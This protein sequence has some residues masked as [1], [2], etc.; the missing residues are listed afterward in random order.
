[1]YRLWKTAYNRYKLMYNIRTQPNYQF[2]DFHRIQKKKDST[3][4]LNCLIEVQS[5]QHF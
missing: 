3:S 4:V 1:M 5:V 2:R